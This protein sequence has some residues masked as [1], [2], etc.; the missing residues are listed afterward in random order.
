MSR[1]GRFFLIL[2]FGLALAMLTGCA[3][4]VY[5]PRDG[6]AIWYYHPELPEAEKAVK[7]AEKAGKDTLCPDEFRAAKCRMEEA[8]R[9]YWACRTEEGIRMAKEATA[10]AKA[11]CP[12]PASCTLT[13]DPPQIV[14]GQSS[15]L[16]FRTSGTV[17]SAMLDGEEIPVTG[18]TKTVKPTVT[19][20]YTGRVTGIGGTQTASAT[21]TVVPPPPPVIP[22]T[23]SAPPPAAPAPAKIA[24]TKS[25]TIHF[26]TD[27]YAI[28]NVDK[29]K[30][31]EAV[32]FIKKF[33]NAKVTI[34]GH[35]DSRASDAYNQRLS[36]KRANAVKQY[37]LRKGVPK[38]GEITTKGYGEKKP[39]ASNKTAKGRALNRRAEITITAESDK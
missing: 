28:R 39:V 3:G 17:K 18:A 36:V 20:T 25:L 34:E 5:A 1:N 9:A 32:A 33:P 13:A 27:K 15:M 4:R 30:L 23:P 14:A 29:A 8:Y 11:L 7:D 2:V 26:A 10:L 21:V 19:T 12:P 38:N 37:F 35:T 31:D 16:I 22:E 24:E 6:S